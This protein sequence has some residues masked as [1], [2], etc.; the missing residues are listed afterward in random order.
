VKLFIAG[1][2]SNSQKLREREIS[3]VFVCLFARREK[4]KKKRKRRKTRI[5]EKK[6]TCFLDCVLFPKVW[7]M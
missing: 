5:F 1:R 3:E 4:K 7:A 2:D 6:T